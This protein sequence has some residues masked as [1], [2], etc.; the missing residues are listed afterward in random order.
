MANNF[1]DL[2]SSFVTLFSIMVVNNWFVTVNMFVYACALHPEKQISEFNVKMYFILFW[3][4]SVIISL[5]LVV[6]FIL[7]GYDDILEIDATAENERKVIKN[8]VE[9][10]LQSFLDEKELERNPQ[11]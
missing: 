9:K 11:P 6:A 1:N 8:K 4:A 10:V 7:D 2:A 5:N 3:Y